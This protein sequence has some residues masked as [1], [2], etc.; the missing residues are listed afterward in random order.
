MNARRAIKPACAPVSAVT[1]K[2][3]CINGTNNTKASSNVPIKKAPMLAV[4]EKSPS[5]KI[6]CVLHAIKAVEQSCKRECCKCHCAC[7][8]WACLKSDV[9]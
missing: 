7:N 5:L 3:G 4:F 2:S 6:E 1:L 9:E 8:G